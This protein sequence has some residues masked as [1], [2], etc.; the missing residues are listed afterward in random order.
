ME[1]RPK[2]LIAYSYAD[3][4]WQEKV[5]S[6]IASLCW[7]D[8]VV[9]DERKL[10]S[11]SIWRSDFDKAVADSKLAVLFVSD[12]F[13]DSDLVKRAKLP[14]MLAKAHETGAIRLS[15]VLVSHCLYEAA[16]LDPS[17]A[18]NNLAEPLDGVSVAKREAVI[19]RIAA[20]IKALAEGEAPIKAPAVSSDD[21]PET[22]DVLR[23]GELIRVRSGTVLQFRR[24][25]RW[26]LCAALALGVVSLPVAFW[27][28]NIFLLPLFLGFGVVTASL[29]A[30]LRARTDLIAQSIVSVQYIRTG[31]RDDALPG[32]QRT[33]YKERAEQILGGT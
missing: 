8:F 30:L 9:W 31:L 15:W 5:Q 22:P 2:I 16:G 17:L 26:L 14:E 28:A 29:A 24:L 7:E 1:K 4:K 3:K 6:A 25:A 12:L 11:G 18:A 20:T 32:R 33:A 10:R 19:G 23:L 21:S 27:R 13:L